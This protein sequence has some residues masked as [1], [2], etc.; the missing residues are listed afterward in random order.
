M[1]ADKKQEGVSSFKKIGYE[2]SVVQ[3]E[4]PLVQESKGESKIGSMIL[5]IVQ[6]I[7][8]ISGLLL[9]RILK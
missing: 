7:Y 5:D 4:T 8:T 1:I 3:S 2:W 9:K 6:R